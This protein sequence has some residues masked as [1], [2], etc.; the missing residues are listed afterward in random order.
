MPA[1]LHSLHRLLSR[2]CW[3]RLAPSQSAHRCLSR[4]SWQMPAPRHSL[5]RL[6]CRRCSHVPGPVGLTAQPSVSV[7]PVETVST[8]HSPPPLQDAARSSPTPA[9]PSQLHH[10][11]V[12]C[13]SREF[14]V[15]APLCAAPDP[16][17]P[18]HLDAR[19]ACPPAGC[20]QC[21]ANSGRMGLRLCLCLVVCDGFVCNGRGE[22]AS[23]QRDRFTGPA[24][25]SEDE[26]DVCKVGR[27][28]L[29]RF[30]FRE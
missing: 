16:S 9:Q 21:G 8:G 17:A 4:L 20:D 18:N 10:R 12:H 15:H 24:L 19:L 2:A 14:R 27:G 11:S 7:Q 29:P 26:Q 3:Q 28:V 30:V 6:L 5:H 13:S 1:P 25:M 22:F 23:G